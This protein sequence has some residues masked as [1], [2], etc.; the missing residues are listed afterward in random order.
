MIR[1]LMGRATL[2]DRLI[3]LILAATALI[4][5]LF[6]GGRPPG[7]RVIVEKDGKV[8]FTAPL[9]AD[10]TVRLEGPLG[11][12]TLQIH[13][14]KVCVLDSPC[15]RKVCMGMGEIARGGELV[16]CIPNHLLIRVSG[17]PDEKRNYD[18]L[19]R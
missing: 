18:F 15:P 9:E 13:S 1:D 19:S 6:Q 8:V 12:T 11:T 14:G 17:E 10:R 7:N 3:V 4:L 5:I 2:L 16:A